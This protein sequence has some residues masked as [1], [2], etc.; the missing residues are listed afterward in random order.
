M[1]D[2][3]NIS[4]RWESE[5]PNYK[6]LGEIVFVFLKDQLTNYEILPEISFRTKDLLSIIK[7]LKKK[8]EKENYTYDKIT[9]KLGV[10]IICLYKSDLDIIDNFIS[11][12]FEV[13]KKDSKIETLKY[14]TLAYLSNH[15]DVSI[16]K[17]I[18]YFTDLSGYENIIFEIQVRT[19]NQHAWANTAHGLMYKQEQELDDDTKRKLFRLVALHEIADEEIQSI[20][21]QITSSYENTIFSVLKSI[22]GKFY[23]YAKIDFERDL[24]FKNLKTILGFLS[25][26]QIGKLKSEIKIFIENNDEKIRIIFKE[27]EDYFYKSIFLS[28]PEIFI[29]WYCIENFSFIIK[30]KW[31]DEFNND[32][33]EILE[34]WWG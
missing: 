25:E 26:D 17:S 18:D 19:L 28:Q 12:N 10:R 23:K 13:I 8:S 31:K 16:K 5:H 15:Y 24:S 21:E 11:K 33:F 27:K 4:E 1:V 3:K 30:E 20:N 14:D 9:D 34:N 29:I 7:K 22:E 6:E 32:E 2:I